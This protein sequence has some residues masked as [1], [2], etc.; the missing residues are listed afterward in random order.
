[1]KQLKEAKDFFD[2]PGKFEKKRKKIIAEAE[3][4]QLEMTDFIGKYRKVSGKE[5]QAKLE[6]GFLDKMI[7][8]MIEKMYA[9]TNTRINIDDDYKKAMRYYLKGYVAY[10]L[11]KEGI[12]ASNDK[13]DFQVEFSRDKLGN[14]GFKI[15]NKEGEET[16][17]SV[18]LYLE[19]KDFPDSMKQ[20][21]KA[22]DKMMEN[23]QFL[24]SLKSMNNDANRELLIAIVLLGLFAGIAIMGGFLPLIIGA[25]VPGATGATVLVPTFATILIGAGAA[26]ASELYAFHK[27][28]KLKTTAN[29][30][31][32]EV[33]AG[34]IAKDGVIL[35]EN[36]SITNK[37]AK[38]IPKETYQETP[39]DAALNKNMNFILKT[40]YS[41]HTSSSNDIFQLGQIM[42]NFAKQN[43]KGDSA[44]AIDDVVNK[45]D[46][47]DENGK[48]DKKNTQEM[49]V[50]LNR[51]VH[52]EMM[53]VGK[54]ASLGSKSAEK[55]VKPKPLGKGF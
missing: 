9:N 26:F 22:I 50:L 44:K 27:D 24:S 42:L 21:T 3:N 31:K 35:E 45:L 49:K 39:N 28:D 15:I 46:L 23:K 16:N 51:M 48:P 20:Y 47:R 12:E 40:I 30:A 6:N 38:I 29:Q 4:A 34:S 8:K 1:M 13:D 33:L 19:H 2:I 53:K 37:I 55:T 25:A 14:L 7:D 43:Y 32:L 18:K 41:V 10:K 5:E 52:L 11:N 54:T 36:V 17:T